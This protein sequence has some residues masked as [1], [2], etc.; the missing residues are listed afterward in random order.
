MCF[1]LVKLCIKRLKAM[2]SE[3][4]VCF[5]D[6]VKDLHKRQSGVRGGHK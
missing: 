5:L 2:H 4:S 6:G 1:A 3:S